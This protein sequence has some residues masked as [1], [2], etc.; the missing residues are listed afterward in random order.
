[1]TAHH[2]AV[3]KKHGVFRL[4]ILPFGAYEPRWFM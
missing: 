3:A 2:R 1:M 4:A